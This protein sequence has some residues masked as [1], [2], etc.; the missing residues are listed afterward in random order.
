M[1]AS[2]NDVIDAL[3]QMDRSRTAERAESGYTALRDLFSLIP[4][5]WEQGRLLQL[6]ERNRS[7][8]ILLL[9]KDQELSRSSQELHI[10]LRGLVADA[11]GLADPTVLTDMSTH[12]SCLVQRY[13]GAF[14]GQD[15]IRVEDTL[16]LAINA[17]AAQLVEVAMPQIQSLKRIVFKTVMQEPAA[18][19]GPKRLLLLELPLGNSLPTKLLGYFLGKHGF[20]ND[21]VRVSLSRAESVTEGG[22]GVK[23]KDL[24]ERKLKEAIKPGDLIIYLD[25]WLSGSN[26]DAIS[27]HVSKIVKRVTGASFLPIGMLTEESREHGCCTSHEKAHDKILKRFGFGPENCQRFRVAFPPLKGACPRPG[28]FFWGESE[29][30]SGYRKRQL[31]GPAFDTIDYRVEMLM[32]NTGLLPGATLSFLMH[33]AKRARAG[34]SDAYDLFEQPATFLK[35]LGHCYEDY[36]SIREQLRGIEHPSNAGDCEDPPQA[37]FEIAMRMLGIVKSRPAI[38]LVGLALALPEENLYERVGNKYPFN[39]HAPVIVPLEPPLTWFHDRFMERIIAVM[40]A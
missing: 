29:S 12:L 10:A 22:R 20:V 26:F 4:Q 17:A 27:E 28:Y 37:L 33:L 24:L 5:D 34:H 18:V 39:E 36:K 21:V 3:L 23:R 32:E 25:E 38:V 40:E 16:K 35:Y 6:H 9:Q 2:T 13:A 30:I 1:I 7:S 31:V 8:V 19:T 11:N 14:R 15:R